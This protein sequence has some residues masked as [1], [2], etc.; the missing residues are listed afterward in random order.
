MVKNII[1]FSNHGFETNWISYIKRILDECGMSNF[2]HSQTVDK[3][4]VKNI[5]QNLIDQFMQ[6]CLADIYT[7]PKGLCYRIFK[8]HVTFENYLVKLSLNNIYTLCRFRCGNHRLPI[9][10]GRWHSVSRNDR[11]CHLCD[12]NDIGD[13]Y[14]YIMSCSALKEDRKRLLPNFCNN[15][16]NTFK[17]EKLFNS[18]NIICL[19]KLCKF[20]RIINVK[21]VPPG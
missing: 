13:E 1:Y 21:V 8:K 16:P 4:V 14:H 7:S 6:N 10:T 2:W 11:V 15:N 19:E 18:N 5:E 17:F 12:S 20:I 3:W 9:E